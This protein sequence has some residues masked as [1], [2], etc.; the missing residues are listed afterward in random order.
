MEPPELAKGTSWWQ[1]WCWD[2]EHSIIQG[3]AAWSPLT[4]ST[5]RP[6]SYLP[7]T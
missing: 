6:T 5:E 2:K 3:G 4:L 1:G 7:H